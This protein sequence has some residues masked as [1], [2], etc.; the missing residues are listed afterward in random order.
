MPR[1]D[2]RRV[3]AHADDGVG[4]QFAGVGEH[5]VERIFARLFA[6]LRVERNVPAEKTLNT[7][8]QCC[9]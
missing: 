7:A 5:L 6:K 9:R 4:A 1:R 3:V 2:F 8:R